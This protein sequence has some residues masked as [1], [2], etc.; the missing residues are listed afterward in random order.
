MNLSK[1]I[2]PRM[3]LRHIL[4]QSRVIQLF[5][6]NFFFQSGLAMK[7][8]LSKW[9]IE[10][11]DLVVLPVAVLDRGTVERANKL[12]PSNCTLSGPGPADFFCEDRIVQHTKVPDLRE[13][14]ESIES[15]PVI[16]QIFFHWDHVKVLPP[17]LVIDRTYAVLVQSQPLEIWQVS[18]FN[19]FIPWFDIVSLKVDEFEKFKV[20]TWH[21]I[22]TAN[23][24]A[25]VSYEVQLLHVDQSRG[26]GEDLR[27][28]EG[29]VDENY[30]CTERV[31]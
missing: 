21:F 29:H 8:A 7:Q 20:F 9:F 5:D 2:P 27:P 25:I 17:R 14:V 26:Q 15:L 31:H 13:L 6:T 18:K 28:V 19:D 12:D 3:V 16:N 22:L 1:L 11:R 4:L 23:L 10:V 24:V 30:F